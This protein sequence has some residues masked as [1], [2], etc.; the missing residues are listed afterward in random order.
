[1]HRRG[2]A[3]RASTREHG[4]YLYRYA[5]CRCEICR[6][7]NADAHQLIVERYTAEGG[8]GSHGTYYRYKTGCRCSDCRRASA[9][10]SRAYKRRRREE[11]VAD[12][13]P[14]PAS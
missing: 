6:K 8:R 14:A 12:S 5:R 4:L 2:P 3:S 9:D 1:M 7:A 11:K 13:L 10:Y